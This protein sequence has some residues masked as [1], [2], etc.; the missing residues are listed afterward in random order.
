MKKFFTLML[1]CSFGQAFAQEF[2]EA[3][4]VTTALPT[5]TVIQVSD[6][7]IASTLAVTL[8]PFVSTAASAGARGVAGKEQLKDDL[9]NLSNDMAAGE[10]QVLEDVRQPA[11]REFFE[12]MSQDEAQMSEV[13][14]NIASGSEL[15]KM[16]TALSIV[17]LAE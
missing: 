12:E 4:L 7:A 10:V 9:A 11:L 17:L 8:A 14:A 16:A 5:A 13:N 3:T 6:V 15:E 2:S 1:L